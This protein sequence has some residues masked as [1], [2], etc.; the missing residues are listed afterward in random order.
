[1]SILE[2]LMD[3]NIEKKQTKVRVKNHNSER[4]HFSNISV[5]PQM[6]SEECSHS[7]AFPAQSMD[8]KKV[9]Y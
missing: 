3:V 7:S 9:A 6:D 5:C 2:V 8:G 4:K 1:M